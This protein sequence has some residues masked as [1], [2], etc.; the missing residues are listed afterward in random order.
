MFVFIVHVKFFGGLY[1]SPSIILNLKSLNRKVIV[2]T[3]SYILGGFKV[4]YVFLL[5][6]SNINELLYYK[7]TPNIYKILHI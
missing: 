4:I 1:F 7:F 3:I 5:M 6:L 2:I